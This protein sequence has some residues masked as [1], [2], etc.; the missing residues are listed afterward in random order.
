MR[1]TIEQYSE[2]KQ[3]VEKLAAKLKRSQDMIDGWNEA[4]K[5]YGEPRD[6][7]EIVAFVISDDG[8][9]NAVT[10]RTALVE[11]SQKLVAN[12]EGGLS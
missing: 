4:A 7:D 12:E 3:K 10:R 6:G 5:V 9:V 1:I 2:A 11:E 8:S